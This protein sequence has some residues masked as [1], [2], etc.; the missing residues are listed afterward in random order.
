MSELIK[1]YQLNGV[2]SN[3][4]FGLRS[5]R[6]KVD[7]QSNFRFKNA[8]DDSFVNVLAQNGQFYGNMIIE[9]NLT[10]NGTQT[11]VNTED[12]VVK[13]K[14]IEVG[15][16]DPRGRESDT[17]A[18]GGGIRIVAYAE[19]D[20]APTVAVGPVEFDVTNAQASEASYFS[21][22]VDGTPIDPVDISDAEDG[23]DIATILNADEGFTTA[24]LAAAWLADVLT[25]SKDAAVFTFPSL[26]KPNHKT[27]SWNTVNKAFEL[28]H[29]LNLKTGLSYF[30]NDNNVLSQTTLG[31]T[32]LSSSLTSVGT[33]TSGALGTGFTTVAVA[34][35]GT[36][37]TTHTLNGV[38][39][40][41]NGNAIG[42][43]TAGINN[44]V[45]LGSTGSAPAFGYLSSLYDSAGVSTLETTDTSITAKQDLTIASGK[46]LIAAGED[47][48]TLGSGTGDYTDN[49]TDPNHAINLEYLETYVEAEAGN[50]VRAATI[51]ES[52]SA[53]DIGAAIPTPDVKSVYAST[54]RVKVSTA[55]SGGSVDKLRILD[56]AAGNVLVDVDKVDPLATGLYII[57]LSGTQNVNGKTLRLEFLQADGTTPA[58]I[59]AGVVSVVAECVKY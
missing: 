45:L 30:I 46:S 58:T 22:T 28:D 38:L 27:I 54:I 7:E 34:Q 39:L 5:S 26:N 51:S 32:V 48:I 10:V 49:I 50:V 36:G 24:G 14:Q 20:A 9:G 12:L 55:C 59:T 47:A 4:Q 18:D 42:A 53:F 35:G 25:I 31:A 57:S 21:V 56:E 43:T 6:I 16:S 44:Q 15:V 17:T 29:A 33:L 1:Q 13:D 40:G 11:I 23:D 19:I 41:N 8:A 2:S 3:V 52:D 37:K